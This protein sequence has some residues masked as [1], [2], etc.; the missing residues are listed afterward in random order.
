MC[1]LFVCQ[2]FVY[3]NSQ[4]GRPTRFQSP[5]WRAAEW[6]HLVNAVK[7]YYQ[8]AAAVLVYCRL[9][10]KATI[11]VTRRQSHV[12]WS[13]HSLHIAALASLKWKPRTPAVISVLGLYLQHLTIKTH[14]P[15]CSFPWPHSH[16]VPE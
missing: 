6:R 3:I 11:K 10:A 15:C 12:L 16:V 5:P 1:P 8:Q 9:V 7:T 2:Y 4:A 14:L 13:A